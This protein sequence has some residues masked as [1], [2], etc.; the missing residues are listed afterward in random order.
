MGDNQAHPSC[1][2]SMQIFSRFIVNRFVFALLLLCVAAVSTAFGAELNV[3]IV[4]GLQ[5]E[6]VNFLIQK[7][8]TITVLTN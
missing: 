7:T 3:P 1:Y 6:V 4:V 5:G 2:L 8:N